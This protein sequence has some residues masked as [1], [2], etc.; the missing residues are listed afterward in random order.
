MPREAED[1]CHQRDQGD[2]RRKPHSAPL[3]GAETRSTRY[4]GTEDKRGDEDEQDGSDD[5]GE[6]PQ[7]HYTDHEP[8]PGEH[9]DQST[10]H[11]PARLSGSPGWSHRQCLSRAPP[12][13]SR[14]LNETIEAVR[15]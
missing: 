10:R 1:H 11:Q 8:P 2:G 5:R 3:V 13:A 12:L 15:R 7:R 14:R 9:D 6:L 4:T